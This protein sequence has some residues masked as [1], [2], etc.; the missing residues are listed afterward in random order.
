MKCIS[1]PC[2]HVLAVGVLAGWVP[3]MLV[4]AQ[5][6]AP[7]P[8]A[9]HPIE[10][11]T[12]SCMEEGDWTTQAMHECA[13]QAHDDWEEEIQRL[14]M[15][16]ERVLGS[17]AREALS[18]AQEAWRSSRDADFAFISAYYAQLYRA[19]LSGGTLGPLAEQLF[20]NAVLQDRANQ[21]QRYLDAL[22]E[23]Q[24]PSGELEMIPE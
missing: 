7:E 14:T 24:A 20:R 11:K 3:A 6:A 13:A 9:S 1:L 8:E 10:H 15:M 19:E 16:L 4:Q 22:E 17:E 12:D 2:R 23:L 18:D 21:L 5:E